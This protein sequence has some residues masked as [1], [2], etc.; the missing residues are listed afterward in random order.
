MSACLQSRGKYYQHKDNWLRSRFSHLFKN[1]EIDISVLSETDGDIFWEIWLRDE[2]VII[3]D[4]LPEYTQLVTPFD[5]RPCA[6]SHLSAEALVIWVPVHF[7]HHTKSQKGYVNDITVSRV[8]LNRGNRSPFSQHT[9]S[10]LVN[11]TGAHR[12]Q[13]ASKCA[14]LKLFHLC[15]SH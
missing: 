15:V 4:S 11:T 5:I 6:H 14:L 3:D 7:I 9:L 2:C 8:I 13:K 1:N 12:I 10:E